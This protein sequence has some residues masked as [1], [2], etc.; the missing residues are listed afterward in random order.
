M[1][2]MVRFLPD[3]HVVL[4]LKISID[5][6]GATHANRDWHQHKEVS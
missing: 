1:A 4:L 5:S 6:V 2:P 3:P